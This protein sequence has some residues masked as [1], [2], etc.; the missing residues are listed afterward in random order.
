MLTASISFSG[1]SC[2]GPYLTGSP[3][4]WSTDLFCH[5]SFC[6][7]SKPRKLRRQV[8]GARGK[9]RITSIAPPSLHEYHGLLGDE[10]LYISAGTSC[11][12]LLEDY[13]G[14]SCCS[15]PLGRWRLSRGL[16]CMWPYGK[17]MPC[18]WP[19]SQ[20][21][22]QHEGTNKARGAFQPCCWT[23]GM[24]LNKDTTSPKG[25]FRA[26]LC[27]LDGKENLQACSEC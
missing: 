7:N 26:V 19:T 8:L 15:R 6:P 22:Q 25:F 5:G 9:G 11:Y 20:H 13:L 3:I 18:S 17:R 10:R 14:K 12:A 23:K 1:T 4:R 16:T 27:A 21:S 24:F 2:A